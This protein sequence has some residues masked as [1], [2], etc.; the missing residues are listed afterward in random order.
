[1]AIC[2]HG[3]AKI[4]NGTLLAWESHQ[5]K[6]YT[7]QPFQ[8]PPGGPGPSPSMHEPRQ[9]LLLTFGP[10]DRLASWRYISR[11]DFPTSLAQVQATRHTGTSRRGCKSSPIC[12]GIRQLTEGAKIGEE[13][14][15]A[16]TRRETERRA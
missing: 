2:G 5:L 12:E 10:D 4:P 3:R 11:E 1:M 8:V 13:V 14:Q 15:H 7:A 9:L 6:S 16:Y